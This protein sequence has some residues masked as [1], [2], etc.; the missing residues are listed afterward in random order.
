MNKEKREKYIEK[1]N[2]MENKKA[3]TTRKNGNKLLTVLFDLAKT[4]LRKKVIRV[5]I[6]FPL[7]KNRFNIH[8]FTNHY[9]KIFP[10]KEQQY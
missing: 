4:S 9:E 8:V 10:N 6:R 5:Q 2:L 1:K 7:S 3:S